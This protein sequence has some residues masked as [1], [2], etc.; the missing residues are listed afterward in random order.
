M[1]GMWFLR[2][3]RRQDAVALC[4]TLAVVLTCAIFPGPCAYAANSESPARIVTFNQ[5]QIY[6]LRNFFDHT[7]QP[8]P[9]EPDV[10]EMLL[11]NAPAGLRR[12]CDSSPATSP[13]GT[14]DIQLLTRISGEAWM[15][16]RCD[17][18]RG[19]IDPLYTE[20][21]AMLNLGAGTM[22][23]VNIRQPGDPARALYHV[24]YGGRIALENSIGRIFL[25]YATYSSPG[26]GKI[27][28]T[29][30]EDRV[31]ILN[32]TPSGIKRA[33]SVTTMRRKFADT[34]AKP[35]KISTYRTR[36]SFQRDRKGRAVA[37]IIRFSERNPGHPARTGVIRYRW[38]L[39][40]ER[41][42]RIGV[43]RT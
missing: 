12:E 32:V 1:V 14:L 4:A 17:W 38:D 39:S 9:M 42:V 33:L 24:E 35:V 5:N 34:A 2:Y 41:F 28:S 13:K 8:A 36:L 30:E 27:T 16:Y 3:S 23:F 37:A 22:S 18:G 7:P 31:L 10:R 15:L 19:S 43:R 20:R 25:I 26:A 6:G 21:L 29:N 11:A 40:S